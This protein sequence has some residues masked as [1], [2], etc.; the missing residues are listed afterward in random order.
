MAL[1]AGSVRASNTPTPSTA[2]NFTLH[3]LG[4]GVWA[5]VATVGG[6]AGSNAGVVLGDDGVAVID[7]FQSREAAE[8]LLAAIHSLTPLP[9]RYVVNTHYHLDHVAGNGVFQDAGAVILAQRNVRAWE[10]SENLKWWGSAI[11]EQARRMVES[12]VLPEIVYDEG[13]QLYLGSREL[14]V[15]SLPGHTGSDSIVVVPDANIVFTGDLFWNETLPNM[16]DADTRAWVSTDDEL[17]RAYGDWTFVPGHGEI[18]DADDVR[19]FRQYL[20]ALRDAV[21]QALRAGERGD[22]LATAVAEVLE[23][24]YGNWAYYKHFIHDDAT[25]TAAEM[26]GRKRLPGDP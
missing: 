17:L 20:Q 4:R 11:P 9:I 14:N 26:E 12:L 6:S 5:A 24:R 13:V 1:I 18:G 15:R 7:T 10:R 19:E 23:P 3:D 16:T 2:K 22:A 8:E 25:Q 21:A